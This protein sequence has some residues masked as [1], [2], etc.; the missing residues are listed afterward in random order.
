WESSSDA[1]ATDGVHDFELVARGHALLFVAA[2]RHDLTIQFDGDAAAGK[3]KGFHQLAYRHAFANF[4]GLP[5]DDCLH[6][7]FVV[8]NGSAIVAPRG[9][10]LWPGQLRLWLK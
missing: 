2:A 9:R 6:C 8:V 4:H 7:D 3:T 1:A 10:G 5:V